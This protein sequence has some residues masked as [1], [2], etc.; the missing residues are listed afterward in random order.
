MRLRDGS[1]RKLTPGAALEAATLE[2]LGEQG[3]P[4]PEVLEV[5]SGWLVTR[6]VRGRTAADP[7]PADERGRVVDALAD[8]TCRL[9][10]LPAKDCPFD[11]TLR[12]TVPL[13]HAAKVD[14]GDL[15]EER[16][17]W[18][19]E[20]LLVALDAQVPGM[21]AREVP[22]VTHGDWCLPNVVL[23]PLSIEVVG[24][25]DTGR[26]GLADRYQD[27]A[28]MTRSLLSTR[29][30]P[31]YGPVYAERFLKR[32]GHDPADDDKLA[33]YRLLDEFF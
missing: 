26:S 30:N 17:N 22:V 13:A 5:G 24:L 31:Q 29:L 14:L 33:F 28:L 4:T 6:E 9:H 21:R 23:D 27:L 2:W 7:W 32:Y 20:Q 16:Q 15:D 10:T 19:A 1:Y 8:M 18:S 25:I 12:V 11:R 3:I